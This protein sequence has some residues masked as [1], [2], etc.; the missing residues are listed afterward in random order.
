MPERE[1]WER[2][3]GVAPSKN[4][5]KYLNG[6]VMTVRNEESGEDCPG[7]EKSDS[8]QTKMAEASSASISEMKSTARKCFKCDKRVRLSSVACRC[9]LL[10]CSKHAQ[11]E[12][13]GCSFDYKAHGRALLM[14]KN[15]HIT[16]NRGLI[17]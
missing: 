13:H 2:E 16:S 9:G 11:P 8:A 1:I 6:I 7:H 17:V 5:N 14:S 12:D 10:F 15:P 4:V 3:D